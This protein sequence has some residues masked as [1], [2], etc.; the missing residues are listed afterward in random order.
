MLSGGGSIGRRGAGR[1]S[2][3]LASTRRSRA[4]R[5]TQGWWL[6]ALPP[7]ACIVG[8]P[9]AASAAR[10]GRM[11]AVPNTKAR[12]PAPTNG[13]V[14]A[15]TR[16]V[17]ADSTAVP[18]VPDT[19]SGETLPVDPYQAYTGQAEGYDYDTPDLNAVLP[20]FVAGL[21][22]VAGRLL[23]VL[24]YRDAF[25][26]GDK[27]LNRRSAKAR[28]TVLAHLPAECDRQDRAWRLAWAR[29]LDDL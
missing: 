24:A 17:S 29:C 13:R 27:P 16:P 6:G 18:H 1:Q 8:C 3:A 12:Q 21:L 20:P 4:A 19:A 28:A 2:S 5:S 10:C 11:A 15:P 26:L 23:A 25:V 22:G 14:P 9:D 7:P